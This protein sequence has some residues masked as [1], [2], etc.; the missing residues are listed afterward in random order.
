MYLLSS[1]DQCCAICRLKD[2]FLHFFSFIVSKFTG[3]THHSLL[4]VAPRS[5]W[6]RQPLSCWWSHMSVY[7]R[8]RSNHPQTPG[9]LNHTWRLKVNSL[10]FKV[11]AQIKVIDTFIHTFLSQMINSYNFWKEMRI[12][13]KVFQMVGYTSCLPSVSYSPSFSIA[14]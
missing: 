4:W 7:A 2:F 13:S 14:S 1:S 9:H 5:C 10:S 8:C 6:C 12:G 11:P 3:L